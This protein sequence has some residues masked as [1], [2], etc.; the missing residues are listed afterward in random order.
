MNQ[1]KS[2]HVMASQNPD[3]SQGDIIAAKQA[4][5]PKGL[6]NQSVEGNSGSAA[7]IDTPK[8]PGDPAENTYADDT[9]SEDAPM[10]HPNRN[11]DESSSDT[12][13]G[14]GH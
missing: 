3:P 8:L 13:Y 11:T 6:M 5:S 14:G 7:E 2:I 4:I 9:E 12:S 10:T 1:P